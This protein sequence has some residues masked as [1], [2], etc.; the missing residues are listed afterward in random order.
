MVRASLHA[1]AVER[2]EISEVNGEIRFVAPEDCLLAMEAR[3]LAKVVQQVA[4]KP[5]RVKVEFGTPSAI[6]QRLAAPKPRVADEAS[7]RALAHPEVQRFQEMFPG[8]HVRTVRD[9]KEG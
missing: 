9:L 1:D 7:E 4:G 6:A 2:S 8:A 5:L 3:D